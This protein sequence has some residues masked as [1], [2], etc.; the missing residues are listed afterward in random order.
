[1]RKI[2]ILLLIPIR[3]WAPPWDT[4]FPVSPP[5]PIRSVWEAVCQVE[6]SGNP[7]AFN[8][9]E[10]AYGIAQIRQ[11]RLNDY[12]HHTGISYKASQMVDSSLSRQVFYY[13]ALQL[14][15]PQAIAR[16]WNGGPQG[17]KKKSTLKY[18]RKVNAIIQKS[19]H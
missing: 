6:S 1:M 7:S 12:E 5:D 4:P 14:S 3:L 10:K 2:L 17:L 13:Y 15:D 11:C 8:K 18:W 16:C 9:K 19:P